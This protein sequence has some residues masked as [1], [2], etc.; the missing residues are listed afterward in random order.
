MNKNDVLDYLKAR[1][2]EALDMLKNTDNCYTAGTITEDMWRR[3]MTEYN[4]IFIELAIITG[5]LEKL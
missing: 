2:K 3:L 4:A 5:N 1:K